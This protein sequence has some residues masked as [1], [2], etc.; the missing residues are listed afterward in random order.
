MS[1][2]D[3]NELQKELLSL[4]KENLDQFKENN[5]NSSKTHEKITS[6]KHI[7]D[8]DEK[9]N[10]WNKKQDWYCVSMILLTLILVTGCILIINSWNVT[11]QNKKTLEMYIKA[12]ENATK[13]WGL[14]CY[15]ASNNS[16]PCNNVNDD[17]KRLYNWQIQ[18][19]FN[20]ET[21]SQIFPCLEIENEI[22]LTPNYSDPSRIDFSNND[23][24][25][26]LSS[27]I[28]PNNNNDNTIN[29]GL[30]WLQNL[31]RTL[32]STFVVMNPGVNLNIKTGN[33][34][35]IQIPVVNYNEYTGM[36][37]SFNYTQAP[38]DYCQLPDFLTSN[39]NSYAPVFMYFNAFTSLNDGDSPS[40]TICS[41]SLN[42]QNNYVSMCL[43]GSSFSLSV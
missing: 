8:F 1:E 38:I 2:E 14:T 39:L 42:E 21:S 17:F 40:F 11:K 33:I 3:V 26:S 36:G 43:P 34:Y 32:P 25:F 13:K 6:N 24:V 41:C 9:N 16:N 22:H 18:D 29:D 19:Y 20:S 37:P 35:A 30:S 4:E 10:A 7:I 5:L 15:S 27:L 28:F 31:I 23:H 12:F